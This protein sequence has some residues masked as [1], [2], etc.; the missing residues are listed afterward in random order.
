[1]WREVIH[2]V[3]VGPHESIRQM[4]KIQSV[5][6]VRHSTPLKQNNYES[7]AYKLTIIRCIDI[8]VKCIQMLN[9]IKGNKKVVELPKVV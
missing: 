1:M 4:T 8:K 7:L 6:P 5:T 9:N 3:Q 2:I